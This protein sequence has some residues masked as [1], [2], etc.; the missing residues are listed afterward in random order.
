MTAYAIY[1][2]GEQAHFLANFKIRLKTQYKIN[3]CEQKYMEGLAWA[4]I[5]C[6]LK[7]TLSTS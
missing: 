5:E 3:S 6:G 4:D 1:I 7:R 2:Q